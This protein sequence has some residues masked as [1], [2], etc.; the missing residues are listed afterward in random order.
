[1][2]FDISGTVILVTAGTSGLGLSVA[3]KLIELGANVVINYASNKDRADSALSRLQELSNKQDPSPKSM[4][5]QADVTQRAEIQRLVAET[6][7]AMGKLD[8]VVSNAGW[9]QFANFSDLDD[10]VDEEVWDR[11]YAANV[12]SHLFL[13]HAAKKYLENANGSFVMTSSVAGAYSVTK[14]AQ[15][16]LAKSLAMVMAPSI[17]VNAVSPGFMETNWIAGFPQSKIDDAREKTLLKRIT[18]VDD[19]ADQIIL[20]IKSESVTGANVVIDAGFS[21]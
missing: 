9:T 4:A 6:V 15:I 21:I 20:L 12:K 7:A 16:H 3:T 18:Q 2:T 11:C 19:V 17:R 13:C 14:A 5:I 8:A 10:N 1:M